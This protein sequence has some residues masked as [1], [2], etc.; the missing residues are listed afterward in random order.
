[1]AAYTRATAIARIQ[2]GLG[3]R[4]DL[5][6]DIVTS[7][8]DAITLLEQGDQLPY[9]LRKVDQTLSGTA[10]ND[11]VTLP[12]DFI[13]LDDEDAVYTLDSDGV[14]HI[15]ATRVTP[16]SK[17]L[18][19]SGLSDA[20]NP[21][22]YTQ[23]GLTLHVMPVPTAAWTVYINYF[24]HDATVASLGDNTSNLWLSNAPLVIIGSAGM[25]LASDLGDPDAVKT[26]TMMY[27]EARARLLR[28]IE[29]FDAAD[30]SITMGSDA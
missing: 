12:A 6:Q 3:F 22:W 7:M 21:I 30:D 13:R 27:T 1:M 10:D 14:T 23:L 29:A 5:S 9:W 28:D 20:S 16:Y 17:L 18:G 24:A 8:D 15:Y 19:Y 2:R 11:A 4:S 25:V 26:F